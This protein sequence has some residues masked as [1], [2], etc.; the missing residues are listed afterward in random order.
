[1]N[2]ILKSVYLKFFIDRTTNFRYTQL[3]SL[4]LKEDKAVNITLTGNLGS[5]KSSVCKELEKLGFQII[6]TGSIFRDIAK[7]KNMSV[8]ELNEL[9]KNDRSIDD[10]ID[11]R[12][13]QLGKELD[14][15]VFDSRLAWHFIPDSFKVF[16]LVDVNEAAK[17]VFNGENR[18][19]EQYISEDDAL[20]GLLTR[21]ELE[22]KRFKELYHINYYDID[23]YNLIL[24][25]TQAT[26]EKIAKELVCQYELYKDKP[27]STK[28]MLN[29]K[30]MYPTH[31]FSDF[32][33]DRLNELYEKELKSNQLHMQG[34]MFI[35]MKDGYNYILN[36]HHH[37]FAS[38]AAGKVFGEVRGIANDEKTI[39]AVM[40]L[41]KKEL[42][43]FEEF[44][45]FTYRNYP[46]EK[47]LREMYK[48]EFSSVINS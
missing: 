30:N 33:A 27:F 9:A 21:A 8:I 20:K 43:D 11:N 47:P 34:S 25:S 16:L 4:R 26:P 3:K 48:A 31:P 46:T 13:T 28:I 45:N 39:S 22:Q 1:M 23:N 44:G 12:S 19:A 17:R 38:M 40:P 29:L 15:V 42:Y 7:E 41:S 5:G 32:Q 37:V 35:T 6:S 10:L 24:E 18:N 14:N 36:G 2:I